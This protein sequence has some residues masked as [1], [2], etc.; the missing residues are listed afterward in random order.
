MEQHETASSGSPRGSLRVICVGTGRDGTQSVT[1]MIQH[2]WGASAE[3]RVM[4]EYCCREFYQAFCDH[5]ETGETLHYWELVR[6]VADCPHESI[7]G[8]GYAAILPLFAA[9]YG[10]GLKLIHL[11]RADRA[12]CIASLVQNCELF[13]T[14]YGYYSSSPEASVKRM[15]AFH[16]GEMSREEWNRLPIGDKFGW[17]YD[18]THTLIASYQSLFDE[19]IEIETESLNSEATRRIIAQAVAPEGDILPP[20][21]HLNAGTIN[22]ASYPKE[23]QHRMHWLM[24]RL[25]IEEVARDEVYALDYFLDKFVAWMGYHITAASELAPAQ[26]APPEKIES[27]LDRAVTAMRRRLREIEEL[28]DLLRKRREGAPPQ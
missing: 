1:H 20:R 6:M 28:Q 11:R 13:P 21:A 27:D 8:N 7:V 24:G 25:N 12:A 9:R 15:A 3:R 23:L 26:P 18:K 19:R 4:H 16:F 22:I 14:A 10:R 17:Y 2:L 5:A